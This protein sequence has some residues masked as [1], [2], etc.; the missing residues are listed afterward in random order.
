MNHT[1]IATQMEASGIDFQKK[2]D[3]FF[4]DKWS[5]LRCPH[6]NNEINLKISSNQ[7]IPDVTLDPLVFC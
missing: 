6:C 5:Q 2:Y 7:E 4:E 3:E 1:E